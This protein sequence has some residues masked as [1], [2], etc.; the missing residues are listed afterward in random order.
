[1]LTMEEREILLEKRHNYEL[2]ICELNRYLAEMGALL[3]EAAVT[4]VENK[5][6]H[7]RSLVERYTERLEG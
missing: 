1:M 5:I 2:E 6:S 3:Q 7:L 4:N